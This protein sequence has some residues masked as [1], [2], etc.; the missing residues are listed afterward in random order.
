MKI[1]DFRL[2]PPYGGFLNDWMFDLEDSAGHVGLIASYER[3]GYR[4]PAS[5]KQK[6][7]DALLQ[8]MAHSEV[9]AA[10]VSVRK[11]PGLNNDDLEKLLEVYPG[12]FIGLAGIQPNNNVENALKEIRRY[13]ID[14]MASCVFMEPGIDKDF[15]YVD[16]EQFYPIY[17]TCQENDIP[18]CFLFGGIFHRSHVGLD[19]EIYNP[20]HIEHILAAFPKLR[21]A[22]SH[23]GLPWTTQ[24]CMCAL[25]YENLYLSPDFYMQDAPGC[26]DYIVGANGVIQDKIIFGS[27]Y[28]AAPIDAVVEGYK[29]VLKP[30]VYDKVFYKN[31]LRFLGE[32]VVQELN[33]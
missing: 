7:M 22:L 23:A 31:A 33:L 12:K 24:A 15:W 29:K 4:L 2:R 28:P 13:V 26:Q 16:D 11:L 18:I 20:I 17:E 25:N 8:E 14:G 30:E 32:K 1:I 5:L 9:T 19:Y 6:S 3:K 21:I 27:C 10:A